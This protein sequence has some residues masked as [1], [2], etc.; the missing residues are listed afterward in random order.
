MGNYIR[1]AFCSMQ[2]GCSLS[3]CADFSPLLDSLKRLLW[4]HLLHSTVIFLPAPAHNV[5]TICL[6]S[7]SLPTIGV[8]ASHA[9]TLLYLA[10]MSQVVMPC[11]TELMQCSGLELA[12]FEQY[13]RKQ[14]FNW[15]FPLVVDFYL[16]ILFHGCPLPLLRFS[17][18]VCAIIWSVS[19]SRSW[20]FSSF[21][22]YNIGIKASNFFQFTAVSFPFVLHR[23][24]YL[25]C[26]PF[27]FSSILNLALCPGT[28]PFLW[29]IRRNVVISGSLPSGETGFGE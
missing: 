10:S 29:R 27:S 20:F 15:T 19:S 6:F 17:L 26:S 18:L 5:L 8:I 24:C 25:L 23:S 1:D 14:M 4:L 16:M 2:H 3:S 13:S 22:S 9:D 21:L 28:F 7:V 12:L 11:F